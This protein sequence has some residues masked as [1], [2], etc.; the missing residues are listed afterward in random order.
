MKSRILRRTV[1]E[2]EEKLLLP[3]NKNHIQ[4]QAEY[5]GG[6]NP[7]GK[8]T[9][10]EESAAVGAPNTL[11]VKSYDFQ[12]ILRENGDPHESYHRLRRHHYLL[13]E[14]GWLIAPAMTVLPEDTAKDPADFRSLRYAVRHDPASGGGFV[15]IN[16]H[17]RRRKPAYHPDVTLTLDT[18]HGIVSTPPVNIRN[19]D[20]RILPYNLPLGDGCVLTASNATPLCRIGSRW[21]FYT[22][23]VPVYRFAGKEA[24]IITLTNAESLRAFL[25]GDRLYV[26][27]RDDCLLY[28]Q[29]GGVVAEFY[30]DTHIRI[31]SATGDSRELLL[32]AP[33]TEG[34]C[35]VISVGENLWELNLTYPDAS[36]TFRHHKT[37]PS[38]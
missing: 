33:E 23:D 31:R 10:L 9:T 36:M 17:L 14:F 3:S 1:S 12:G 18:G 29:D 34:N 27:D 32:T 38:R 5:H 16:N 37:L 22:D 28:R 8:L 26:T 4:E 13:R 21:F 25:L 19:Q 30:A 20:I 24:E 11:P 15:W 7:D 2:K 35:T 6:T